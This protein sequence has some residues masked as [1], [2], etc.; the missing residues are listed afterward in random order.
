MDVDADG[1]SR[2]TDCDDDD[3]DVGV[4]IWHVDADGDGFGGD[5]TV[6]QCGGGDGL[7]Q[8]L[9]D[10]NDGDP[11]IHPSA[12]ESCNEI[13]DNC[14]GA[15]DENLDIP[16][17]FLDADGDRFGVATD[18]LVRCAQPAG[19]VSDPTDCDDADPDV[20]P[21]TVETCN[22]RDDDC[23]GQVDDGV[24]IPEW[25]P[26]EDADRYGAATG[27]LVQCD[28][29]AGY[30]DDS[31]DCDDTNA[32]IHPGASERC[33]GTRDED[34]DGTVD[35][36]EAV[37][38]LT[39]Y[40]DTD[41]DGFGDAL[42]PQNACTQPSD[43]VSDATDCDDA[44]PTTNPAASEVCD[45]VDDNCDG[46]TDE[47]AAVDA[48]VWFADFDADGFGDASVSTRACSLPS[49]YLADASDCDDLDPAVN[50]SE[51][52]I[53]ANGI[54]DDCDGTG[55]ACGLTGDNVL[56]SVGVMITGVAVGD[57]SGDKVAGA[58]DV[59][60]DGADD[61]LV[62]GYGN[63][64]GSAWLLYGP[65]TTD[66]TL[67]SAAASLHETSSSR[68]FLGMAVSGIGDADADGYDDFAVAAPAF[69]GFGA[70]ESGRV[71]LFQD[72]V[73]GATAPESDATAHLDG[74]CV[75]DSL[76]YGGAL[77][78]AG[79]VDDDGF[80][81][82]IVG[83]YRQDD[84][85]TRGGAAGAAYVMGGPFSSATTLDDAATKVLGISAYDYAAG[86]VSGAG[87][88]D[89]D[90]RDDLLV[91]AYGEDSAG[92]SAG[93]AY[94]VYGG[95]TGDVS[96]ASADAMFTGEAV[97][98]GAGVSVSGAGD[99]DGDGLADVLVGADHHGDGGA[100][101]LFTHVLAGVASLSAADAIFTG[102]NL[103]DRAG[104]AVA[105]AGLL[106]GDPYGDILVGAYGYDRDPST[107]TTETGAAYVFLGPV[108]G[109]MSV[110]AADA[111]YM[112]LTA[113]DSAG[114]AVA[115]AG[116][117]DSDGYGD[118]LIGAAGQDSGG[119]GAGATFLILGG[120]G[121]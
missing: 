82:F 46:A 28:G 6:E 110:G 15:T 71:Y 96:L 40:A 100:A 2:P 68:V 16:V 118:F 39:F 24:T 95:G 32:D 4:E 87:D 112:G 14:D 47:D 91:G 79:D 12:V 60:A 41:S 76:G 121:M 62:G 5:S 18:P 72:P 65:L 107:S 97:G 53:C 43:F 48:P 35:E 11:T 54:D 50:P 31:T 29:P 22:S 69:G 92:A 78:G 108:S 106:N 23:D 81:D 10:C 56:G 45:G 88:V 93:A 44:S 27:G 1:V 90:G 77:A 99:V 102:E 7:S 67:V 57:Y 115:S 13:D 42:A 52:E 49:G 109:T 36:A 33:D 98:D 86:S 103:N 8:V 74:D 9:G 61:F 113:G 30:V 101:Y 21:D 38:A 70:E 114:G 59:N 116:D 105:G 80:A 17:W 20:R 55:N 64:P 66:T 104:C 120:E 63:G 51:A 34:C 37:D 83:S 89:G 84:C 3:P 94:V 117:I 19:Y 75:G 119:A 25:H 85:A 26:D 73:S 111:R 58:G